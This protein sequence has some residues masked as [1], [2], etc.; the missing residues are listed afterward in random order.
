[1]RWLVGTVI[2]LVVLCGSGLAVWSYRLEPSGGTGTD[3]SKP[4][5]STIGQFIPLDPPRPA[6]DITFTT[7]TGETVR[8][9]DFRGRP[10]LINLWATWC[11][12][13]V[14]E[15][16]SLDRLQAKLGETGFTIL[17][18]SQDREGARVVDPFLDKLGLS[19][20]KAYLDPKGQV[21]TAF[22][23]RGL[24]TSILV[25]REGSMV[26]RLEGAA[27]WDAR[28]MIEELQRQTNPPARSS[29][30]IKTSVT[31]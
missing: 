15:M 25:D 30:T 14:R 6:P 27:E 13:C 23:V 20:L 26:G 8:L 9:A 12:P 29:D 7:L 3:R 24:P 17:A 2:V 22:S 4:Q 10:V 31:R 21:G 19:A 16:P 28:A 1:M 11:G 5:A 18:I